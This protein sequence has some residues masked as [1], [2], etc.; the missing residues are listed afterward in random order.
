MGKWAD[1]SNWSILTTLILWSA[2][3]FLGTW[4]IPLSYREMR[5]LMCAMLHSSM[6]VAPF[7]KP[8]GLVRSWNIKN[9]VVD[10]SEVWYDIGCNVWDNFMIIHT[11]FMIIQYFNSYFIMKILV[12]KH[13]C[14]VAE[15][16]IISRRINYNWILIPTTIANTI[17]KCWYSCVSPW[18]QTHV[19]MLICLYLHIGLKIRVPEFLSQEP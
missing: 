12:N 17:A 18:M 7:L 8:K 13:P 15:G 6:K 9:W 2:L 1:L 11:N 5:Q 3:M 4:R 16:L 14:K 19:Q 10:C